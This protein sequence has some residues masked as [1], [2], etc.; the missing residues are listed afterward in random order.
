[1]K[2]KFKKI[3]KTKYMILSWWYRFRRNPK[4][5]RWLPTIYKKK[6]EQKY[7]RYCGEA[8]IKEACMDDGWTL[9]WVCHN[10]GCGLY[11]EEMKEWPVMF[12]KPMT[13][14]QLEKLGFEIV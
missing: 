11:Y 6:P 7:C 4:V 13:S 3:R 9:G 8:M 12:N 5:L 1:M 10:S 14:K 2:A